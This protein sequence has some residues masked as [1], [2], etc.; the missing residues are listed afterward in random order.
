MYRFNTLSCLAWIAL[1]VLVFTGRL[2]ADV[3]IKSYESV[4][5]KAQQSLVVIKYVAK[6]E[7]PQG[8]QDIEREIN[9]LAI[10]DNGLIV[11]SSLQLGTSRFLRTVNAMVTP[12]DIKVLYGDDTVGVEADLVATD[13]ELDLSW[14]R[15]KDF[16]KMKNK[17]GIIDY[18]QP[19]TVQLGSPIMVVA[20]LHKYYGRAIVISEGRIAGKVEKPRSMWVGRSGVE[21]EP[22]MPVFAADGKPV[23][24]VTFQVPDP[25]DFSQREMRD[26]QETLIIDAATLTKATKRALEEAAAAAEEEE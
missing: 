1:P 16:A 6:F 9:A 23:G 20:R 2:S 18:A 17:P 13:A 24:I 11:C 12:S 25:E 3:D 14:L 5:A 7:T 15:I 10:G 26:A 19:A 21:Q 22:G 8:P 4:M